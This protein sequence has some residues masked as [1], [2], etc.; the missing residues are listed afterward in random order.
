MITRSFL[1]VGTLFFIFSKTSIPGTRAGKQG[2]ACNRIHSVHKGAAELALRRDIWRRETPASLSPDPLEQES[3][4]TRARE[5]AACAPCRLLHRERREAARALESTGSSRDQLARS[6][7]SAAA[8][9]RRQRL[10]RRRRLLGCLFSRT[11]PICLSSSDTTPF[12]LPHAVFLAPGHEGLP[13]HNDEGIRISR[14][15]CV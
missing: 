6:A 15:P 12:L 14:R 13:R 9:P 8:A 5:S 7:P 2:H 1:L 11:P 3:R 10:R 4:S